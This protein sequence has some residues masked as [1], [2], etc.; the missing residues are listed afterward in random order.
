MTAALR[1]QLRR[2]EPSSVV[3]IGFSGGGAL[4][5]L[6]AEHVPDTVAVVTIA[7]N[8]DV[9]AWT[10]HHH[11][12][13]LRQSLDPA[14]RPALPPHVLQLHLQGGRDEV[15]PPAIVQRAI[16]RQPGAVGRLYPEFDHR[17]CWQR[18]WPEL[19]SEL[20]RQ[21]SSELDPAAQRE[22]VSAQIAVAR[23]GLVAQEG[24]EPL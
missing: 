13:P 21:L 17:C 19:L 1:W 24:R 20:D 2:A 11:Y 9:A 6:L 3:L 22:D 18:A 15:V 16:E 12:A 23:N 10:A 4:A 7:G 5:M 8:L 14:L